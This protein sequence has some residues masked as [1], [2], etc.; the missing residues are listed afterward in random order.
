MNNPGIKSSKSSCELLLLLKKTKT[1]QN[2]TIPGVT[3]S[4]PSLQYIMKDFRKD[5]SV[6]HNS[7][8]H[9]YNSHMFALE[10]PITLNNRCLNIK[11]HSRMLILLRRKGLLEWLL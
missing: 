4:K 8:T 2:N 11:Y 7:I 3:K 10:S 1:K 9:G 6:A 5:E